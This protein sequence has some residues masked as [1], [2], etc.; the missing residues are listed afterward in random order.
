MV[1]AVV[2][3][4]DSHTN[5]VGGNTFYIYSDLLEIRLNGTQADIIRVKIS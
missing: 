5:A 1:D 3:R 4:T 2:D